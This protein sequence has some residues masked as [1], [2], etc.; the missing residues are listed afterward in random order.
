MF[1]AVGP[2]FR[3]GGVCAITSRND[4]GIQIGGGSGIER[5]GNGKGKADRVGE[6]EVGKG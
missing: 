2:M 5:E 3:R 4:E 6:K 1:V